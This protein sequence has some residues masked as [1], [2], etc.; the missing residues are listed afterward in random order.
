MQCN[1]N[2]FIE[3]IN[4]HGLFR[5]ALRCRKSGAC[6]ILVPLRYVYIGGLL[7]TNVCR[8]RLEML[9]FEY[10]CS[11]QLYSLFTLHKEIVKTPILNLYI[12]NASLNLGLMLHFY[13]PCFHN[14]ASQ[15]NLKDPLNH[16]SLALFFAHNQDIDCMINCTESLVHSPSPDIYIGSIPECTFMCSSNTSSGMLQSHVFHRSPNSSLFVSVLQSKREVCFFFLFQLV[17]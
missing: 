7:D 16:K 10:Y 2:S 14:Y 5:N 12:R 4:F 3:I 13:H 17:E 1:Y 6:R 9:Y 15:K 8:E 11:I